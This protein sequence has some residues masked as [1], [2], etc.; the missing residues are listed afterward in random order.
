VRIAFVS[1]NREVLPDPVVPLGLLQVMAATPAHHPHLFL[2]LCFEDDPLGALASGL[3]RTRLDLVAIGLRNIQNSDYSDIEAN[4]RY[5]GDLVRA[6]RSVTAAPIVLGGAGFSVMPLEILERLRADWGIAGEAEAAFPALVGALESGDLEGLGRTG[7]VYRMREGR[8]ERLPSGPGEPP[9]LDLDALPVAGREAVDPRYYERVGIE[10]VQ[11]KR[12]CPMRC[13]YCTYPLIEGRR[14]RVRDPERVVDEMEAA[15]R[16]HPSIDHFFVV[17]SVFNLPPA[18]A[19]AVCGALVRRG[20]STPWTCYAN[21]IGFDR[22]LA[23][24]MV[25]ARCAGLEIGADSGDDVVLERLHKGFGTA[26]IARMHALCAEVGLKDCLTFILGTPG[27]TLD[28]VRRTL[29]FLATTEPFAAILMIWQD[30]AEA[31]DPSLARQR[32]SLREG[33]EGLL[34]EREGDH[35]RWI[36]PP[37][38][39]AFDARLF[40]VL[41]KRGLRGP[42]WQHV[43]KR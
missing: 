23:E 2:D 37:L 41:R 33:I 12:G 8:A 13:E 4:L 30:E 14:S 27:E 9:F 26:D 42:L 21:P 18:H 6:V 32:R 5:Y 19:R 16:T 20:W 1:A 3:A 36:V 38:G 31:R 10:A 24:A 40:A 15:L 34:R 11:T 35:P 7:R 25:R 43:D 28:D 17:D 29:D 22:A 39:V